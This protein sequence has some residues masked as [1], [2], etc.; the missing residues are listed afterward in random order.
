[1]AR[2][3]EVQCESTFG[4]RLN[5]AD[6]LKLEQLCLATQRPASAVLRLL[7]RLAE[8]THIPPIEFRLKQESQGDMHELVAVGACG[9]GEVQRANNAED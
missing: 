4:V 9:D 2:R 1:M 8:P 6:R 7:V 5:T 3:K